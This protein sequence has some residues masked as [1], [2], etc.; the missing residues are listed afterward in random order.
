MP[1]LI[2]VRHGQTDYNAQQRYQGQI[3]N[4]LNAV[5]ISQAEALRPRLSHFKLNAVYAS[6]LIRAR[7]TA[8]IALQGHSSGLQPTLLPALREADGGKFEGLTWA[9]MVA[10]YPKEVELWQKDRV[11]HGP[12]DGENV[13]QV[14]ERVRQGLD[15][16]LKEHSDPEQTVLVVAHGGILAVLLCDLMGVDLN[17]QWQ[18]RIDTC[19]ISIVDI[20]PEGP[21]L[22]LFNDVMH[23]NPAHLERREPNP[24]A[25]QTGDEA[26]INETT[27]EHR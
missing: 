10:Q 25:G 4:P 18:W 20:Y 7:Q 15:H 14:A 3:D 22:S 13:A 19:S 8:E 26:P 9:E 5:G 2:L 1:K 12:P 23:L 6:D 27:D 11:H 16:I 21:I 17:R 24:A